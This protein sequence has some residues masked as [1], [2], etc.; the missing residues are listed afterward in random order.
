MN[1]DKR[2]YSNNRKEI[3]D[4]LPDKFRTLLDI[5]C[6][7]G[8]FMASL[9]N[10]SCEL[11]GIEPVKEIADEAKLNKKLKIINNSIELALSELP[12]NYFDCITCNDVL[13]HLV[14][15]DEIILKLKS[16]LTKKGVL[17]ASIPNVRFADNIKKLI[18]EKD[19]KYEESGILD[20][21]HLRFFTKKS[22]ERMF[23][24]AG[25]NI[26]TL[27]GIN[28]NIGPIKKVL[29]FITI[30]H[31]EDMK[32]VQFAVVARPSSQN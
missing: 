16:K 9:S 5:G 22:I 4:V 19:W 10:D 8:N 2:Y 32:Y 17:V 20:K 1:S 30:G 6:G 12:N 3:A 24:D 7:T 29:D 26:E 31:T 18:F 28:A 14:N 21:T 27:K 13:E 23:N 25:Y 15:P 11:W